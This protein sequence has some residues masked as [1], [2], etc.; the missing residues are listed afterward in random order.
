M[1]IKYIK[2][3]SGDVSYNKWLSFRVEEVP[4]SQEKYKVIWGFRR[5]SSHLVEENKERHHGGSAEREGMVS[6]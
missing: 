5:E 4:C 1:D 3:S 6:G 2:L